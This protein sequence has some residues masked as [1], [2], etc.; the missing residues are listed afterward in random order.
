M[1]DFSSYQ[2]NKKGSKIYIFG[3]VKGLVSEAKRLKK[4]IR[5]LRFDIGGLPISNEERKGLKEFMQSKDIETNVEP[6]TPERVYAEKLKRFG[7]VS[8]PP[9]S[10]TFFMNYCLENDIE[11]EALDMD[12]EH[13]T[14]AYCEHVTGTQW[15][16][17]A[18]REKGLRRKKIEAENPA[19]FAIEWDQ[20]INK[21]KGFQKLEA[22]REKVIA[23]NI[24]R[25]SERGDMVAVV[26]E[27][28]I[29][30]IFDNLKNRR[31][32]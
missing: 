3:I 27:E 24:D 22:H 17:Q 14:M 8:L 31:K 28:R 30:G 10:Y 20:F 5:S 9:P 18:L 13:Y 1:R 6:S 23:K 29:D 32:E 21:L 12:E 25:I 19:E 4:K 16:R 7:E 11:I 15:M 2:L 26:E